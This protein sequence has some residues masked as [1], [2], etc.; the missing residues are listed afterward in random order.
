MSKIL[1][2]DLGTNS[3][4]W[5]IVDTET[6]SIVDC[7]A[8]IFPTTQTEKNRKGRIVTFRQK[9]TIKSNLIKHYVLSKPFLFGLTFIS[10]LTF[11]L[12]ITDTKNW[13]F[14]LN[15]SLTALLTLLTIFHQ[16]KDEK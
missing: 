13:Q 12:T 6:N 1:G 3:I 14:W 15:I 16:D 7:G 8:R 9:L 5:A 2:L 11:I 10:T 4:G